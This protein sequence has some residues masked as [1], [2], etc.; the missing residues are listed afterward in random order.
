MKKW[1]LIL[2]L[3]LT[4]IPS[5][6]A[7]LVVHWTFDDYSTN[8]PTAFNSVN[9]LYNTANFNPDGNNIGPLSVNGVFNSAVHFDG[10]DD[11]LG[12]NN[13]DNSLILTNQF[14]IMT[15]LKFDELSGP[16]PIFRTGGNL[17]DYFLKKWDYDNRFS[18][19]L[20]GVSGGTPEWQNEFFSNSNAYINDWLHLAV[21][22]DEQNVKFYI[23]GILDNSIPANGNVVFGD[24][25]GSLI[26]SKG[27]TGIWGQY[28]HGAIDDMRIYNEALTQNEILLSSGLVKPIPEPATML[29]FGTGLAGAFFRRRLV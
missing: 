11:Y 23:N 22:Y 25:I 8:L 3:N 1:I 26:G 4:L 13:E 16:K 2:L 12:I 6:N 28:F 20:R 21:T 17:G 9:P 10:L 18:I 24:S 29:L 19:R 15:W 7:S 14:T 27:E 5:A